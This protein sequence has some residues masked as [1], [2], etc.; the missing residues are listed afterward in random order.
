MILYPLS[1]CLSIFFCRF[2]ASLWHFFAARRTETEFLHTEKRNVDNLCGYPPRYAGAGASDCGENCR[3]GA[4]LWITFL[5]NVRS[6][7]PPRLRASRCG[8]FSTAFPRRFP[9]K[10]GR[11][12][13]DLSV[14]FCMRLKDEG[15][16]EGEHDRGAHAR[17]FQSRPL[18]S[19]DKAAQRREALERRRI[20]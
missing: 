4:K 1:L 17:A 16:E 10:K 18:C 15:S 9:Q 5:Q 6:E 7:L 20:Q 12:R 19:Y 11:V 2:S 14:M 13:P 8:K 3:I